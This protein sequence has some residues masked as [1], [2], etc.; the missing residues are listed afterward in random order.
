VAN[1]NSQAKITLPSKNAPKSLRSLSFS[2]ECMHLLSSLRTPRLG[3]WSNKK[4]S[5]LTKRCLFS[6]A[7]LVL[8]ANPICTEK[9]GVLIGHTLHFERVSLRKGSRH[10]DRSLARCEGSRASNLWIS[11]QVSSHLTRAGSHDR[12][13]QIGVDPIKFIQHHRKAKVFR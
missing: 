7:F 8:Q 3:A 11:S 6:L 9:I 4:P 13:N 5:I 1:T 10:N 12:S 2:R